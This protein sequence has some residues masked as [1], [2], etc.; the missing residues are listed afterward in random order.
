MDA[1][2]RYLEAVQ[3]RIRGYLPDS[4]RDRAS[5]LWSHF[6]KVAGEM[7]P[8]GGGATRATLL[9]GLRADSLPTGLPGR[10]RADLE[11]VTKAST[12]VLASV[13]DNIH[14][15]TRRQ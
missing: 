9:D 14:G 1:G 4:D 15:L 7:T 12:R 11:I 5:D 10:F 13:K 8:A 3:D 6:V 2:S